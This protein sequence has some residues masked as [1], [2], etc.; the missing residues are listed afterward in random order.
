MPNAERRSGSLGK[1]S[2]NVLPKRLSVACTVGT[3]LFTACGGSKPAVAPAPAPRPSAAGAAVDTR[4]PI[5]RAEQSLAASEYAAAERDF[6]AEATGKHA[7]R[8]RLGLAETLLVTGRYAEAV[9]AARS[10]AATTPASKERALVLEARARRAEGALDA[11]EKALLPLEKQPGARDAWLLLGEIRIERGRRE[12]ASGP[13]LQLIEDYNEERIAPEDGHALA[14]VGRAAHLL[15]SARDAND[16]FG[17]AEATGVA[18]TQ[19]LLFRAELFLEKYDPGQAEEVLSEVLERAPAQPEALVLMAHTRLDQALDF[20]EAERLARAALA[21]NPRIAGAFF[22]LAGIALRDMDLDLAAKH[23]ADGLRARPGDLDLLSLR[24]AIHFV[25]SQP[26]AFEA[27]RKAVLAANPEWSRFYAIVGEFAD[28]EHRYD[29]IV[30]LMREAVKLDPDDPVAL[31]SLGLNLIRAGRDAEGTAALSRAFTVDPYNARVF[32]TLEL[33]EKVIPKDYVSVNGTRFTIRYHKADRPLLERYVPQLLE[34]AWTQLVAH[35]GFTPKT[36]VGI[37]L[38]ADRQHFAVRTSGLPE[39]A[40]QGVC[41]GHTLASMSPQKESFN[42]GMT[43]WHELAHVFHIQLSASHVPRWFTEGLAEYETAITRAEWA[44]EQDPE[45]YEMRRAG[46]LPSIDAMNRAFTRAE[47]LSD[48]ATAYYASSRL[49]AMLGERHGMA[50]LAHM[51]RL[52]SEGKRTGEVFQSALGVTPAEEDRR[53]AALLDNAL[54]RYPKQFVPNTR[55]PALPAAFEQV[56]REPKNA[57]KHSVLAL[58]LLRAGKP[59]DARR[60]LTAALKLD[61][62]LPDAR[63]LSAR[64]A[65]SSEKHAEAASVLRGML[66]DGSDGYEVQMLLAEA[67]A[68]TSD[69]VTRVTALQAAARLDP[70]QSA[71]LYALL[72]HA[73]EQSDAEGALALLRKL[74]LLSEHDASIYRELLLRLVARKEF[75]EAVRVG[76]SAV[77]VDITGFESHFAFAEALAATGD[78]RRAVFEY[79]SALLCEAEPMRMVEAKS[80]LKALGVRR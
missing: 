8:A 38:Y 80:R 21:V 73:E 19:L 37:E 28:W 26:A 46:R 42:L 65:L 6:R 61:P 11:A 3:L 74:A 53:F 33:F 34:K 62:K 63:Y 35:Y 15:R 55:A 77:N 49:V 4:A 2:V 23:I 57:Q 78:K 54:A 9:A 1:R 7:E 51:L 22:V 18:D 45:L 66:A 24:A 41:F 48:M 40:I 64:L 43:L 67:A 17:E 30:E 29:G 16:A 47:Q 50:R 32:N 52:W 31:A 75:A 20:V 10:A 60:A 72:R 14:L 12:A 44:R 58:A 56:D 27:D 13:L 79:E 68:G 5:D 76:E 25:A 39:T 59:D 70:T 36:P 71:P 69:P